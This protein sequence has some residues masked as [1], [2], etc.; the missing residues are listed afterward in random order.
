V[1]HDRPQSPLVNECKTKQAARAMKLHRL[2]LIGLGLC[3]ALVIVSSTTGQT[4]RS[5]WDE[6]VPTDLL[7]KAKGLERTDLFSNVLMLPDAPTPQQV[8]IIARLKKAYE[9]RMGLRERDPEKVSPEN[10]GRVSLALF[11]AEVAAATS[12]SEAMIAVS[13]YLERQRVPVGK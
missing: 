3:L 12:E 10:L 9:A 7:P 8:A 2:S 4:R 5:N 6:S 11:K 13:E 1:P